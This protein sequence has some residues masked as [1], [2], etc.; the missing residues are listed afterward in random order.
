MRLETP[1]QACDRDPGHDCLAGSGILRFASRS[2][3]VCYSFQVRD[4]PINRD[5]VLLEGWFKFNLNLHFY[6]LGVS[7]YTHPSNALKYP[8]EPELSY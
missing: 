2:L 8:S 5:F 4:L 7:R 6:G 3:S 1:S